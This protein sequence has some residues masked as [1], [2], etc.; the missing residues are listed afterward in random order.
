MIHKQTAFRK[1]ER[2]GL[3]DGLTGVKEIDMLE[4]NFDFALRYVASIQKQD[5]KFDEDCSGP[6]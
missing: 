1:D 6:L 3:R 2:D 5:G 4:I